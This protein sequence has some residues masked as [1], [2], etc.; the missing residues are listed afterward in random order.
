MG[1]SWGC[2]APRREVN[3]LLQRRPTN[4]KKSSSSPS[5][6]S[7]I[8]RNRSTNKKTEHREDDLLLQQQAMAA[9]LLFRQHQ[10][11]GTGDLPASLMNRSTSV[12]YPSP[13]PRKQAFAK[14][15]SSRQR[16]GSDTLLHPQELLVSQDRKSVEGVETKHFILVHGGGFGAWCWYKTMTLLEEEGFKVDAVD[17]NGSG[18]QSSDSNSITSLAQY[19]KP[20]TNILEKLEDGKKV[21]LVGHDFGG[22]CISYAMELFSSKVAKSIFIAATML[23]SGQSTLDLFSRQFGANDLMQQAQIFLYANGKDQPPTAIEHNKELV[24]DLFFNQSPS[25]DVVLAS[26]SMRPVPFAPVMEKLSLS[27]ANYGSVSR[28]YIVT[29]ED[30][31]ISPSLQEI[32]INSNPPEHVFRIKGSDHSPFFS[33]PQALHKILVEIAQ[34]LPK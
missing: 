21:V 8:T 22:A 4:N 19:V 30:H 32:M 28:F 15:S 34:I 20:L 26:V 18:V 2:F 23:A 29:Q 31:A 3:N 13:A 9:A 6:D 33:R 1:N 7:F 16:S 5:H 17:L 12:V 11:N 27:E 24:K 14:S 10:R 25:K